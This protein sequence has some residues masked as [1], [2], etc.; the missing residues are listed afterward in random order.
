MPVSRFE[1]FALTTFAIYHCSGPFPLLL[2]QSCYFNILP[3]SDLCSLLFSPF[4]LLPKSSSIPYVSKPN[5]HPSKP[6]TPSKWSQIS[7]PPNNSA[8]STP[9]FPAAPDI[10]PNV[11]EP[12]TTASARLQDSERLMPP[13]WNKRKTSAICAASS[14]VQRRIS[15]KRQRWNGR[16]TGSKES[17][18]KCTQHSPI[19]RL[20]LGMG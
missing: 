2:S 17:L 6:T 4:P 11:R 5:N 13:S 15:R 1:Y 9:S 7:N 12:S 18:T 10:S 3:R 20:V 16:L 8:A 14:K 19:A